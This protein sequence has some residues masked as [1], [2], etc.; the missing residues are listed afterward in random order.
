M[1]SMVGCNDDEIAENSSSLRG[2]KE[3]DTIGRDVAVLRTL[4]SMTQ[5]QMADVMLLSRITLS[6][7]ENGDEGK[8]MA[9]DTAFRIYYLASEVLRN[10][11]FT[12]FVRERAACLRDRVENE[13]LAPK[14][15]EI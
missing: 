12:E 7:L 5:Q 10:S 2:I 4:L 13:L 11:S 6:K 1:S 14:R 3:K 15:E 9:A 8:T